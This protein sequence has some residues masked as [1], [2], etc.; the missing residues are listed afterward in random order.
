MAG[1]SRGDALLSGDARFASRCTTLGYVLSFSGI[2][3]FKNAQDIHGAVRAVGANDF[4]VETDSPFL[5]PSPHR[6]EPNVPGFVLHTAQAVAD[7]RGESLEDVADRTTATARR[8]F[9]L[10]LR[11]VL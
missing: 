9:G 2:A 3:T 8:V 6:G 10:P 1:R 7:L 11:D 5:A 4:T